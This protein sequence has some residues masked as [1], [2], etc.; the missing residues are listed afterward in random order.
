[1]PENWG[2][3]LRQIMRWARGHNQATAKYSWALLRNHRTRWIEKLDG[4]LLL[5]VYLMSPILVA[6]WLLG[7]VL[8]YAGEPRAS[9]MLILLV[10]SYSTLG[11]FAV[12]Y[13]ITAA[14]QIDGSRERIRLLPFVFLGF[15]VSLFSVSRATFLHNGGNGNGGFSMNG[16]VVWDKTERTNTFRNHNNGPN[17]NKDGN[18]LVRSEK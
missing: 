17:G 12:F 14:A 7:T 6:G 4:V 13:E 15:L 18:S 2:T 16:D 8:W 9:L 10:T 3:R 11:N 5:G 1:V